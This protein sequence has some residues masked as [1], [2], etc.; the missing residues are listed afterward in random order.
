MRI[1][2]KREAVS[3]RSRPSYFGTQSP[4]WNR[5]FHWLQWA[6]WTLGGMAL[7]SCLF[8]YTDMAFFQIAR[9][10]QFEAL[11]QANAADE[12][13]PVAGLMG[14][15]TI[16]RIGLSAVVVE[17]NDRILRR[18]VGHIP[19]TALPDDTGTVGL[20]GHRDTFF[21]DLGL[22]R[23]NDLIVLETLRGT[24]RYRV[25]DAAI[26]EPN[27]VDVLQSVQF[28]SLVLVTCYPFHFVGPAPRRYVVTAW[29]VA[30]P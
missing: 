10:R 22:V 25:A 17:G 3:V 5:S 29:L 13:A 16:P 26:V 20:A 23:A 2:F 14:K 15:I 27:N 1:A 21:R 30:K 6:C 19:G 9:T 28:Q 18:A 12:M 24:Y 8:A 11:R 4:F 7:C